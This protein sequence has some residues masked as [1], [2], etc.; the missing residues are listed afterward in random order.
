MRDDLNVLLRELEDVFD[1]SSVRRRVEKVCAGL[2]MSA[3]CSF[4]SAQEA[5]RFPRGMHYTDVLPCPTRRLH[6][7]TDYPSLVHDP[8]AQSLLGWS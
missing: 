5:F 3:S 1:I 4:G 2:R 7:T 6:A 8:F